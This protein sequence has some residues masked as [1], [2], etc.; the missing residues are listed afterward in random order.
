MSNSNSV[1]VRGEVLFKAGFKFIYHVF[2]EELL[3]AAKWL[4]LLGLKD[5]VLRKKFLLPIESWFFTFFTFFLFLIVLHDVIF[6]VV[7]TIWIW[8][9]WVFSRNFTRSTMLKYWVTTPSTKRILLTHNYKCGVEIWT[10]C[11]QLDLKMMHKRAQKKKRP[12]NFH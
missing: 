10:M 6:N 4:K 9:F 5:K 11:A 8:S 3:H 12:S 1:W 2:F 7:A